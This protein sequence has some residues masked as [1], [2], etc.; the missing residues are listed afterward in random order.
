MVEKVVLTVVL[1]VGEVVA[2]VDHQAARLVETSNG[3][4][5]EEVDAPQH[6]TVG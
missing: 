2:V 5:S 1:R 6:C 4:V 3:S